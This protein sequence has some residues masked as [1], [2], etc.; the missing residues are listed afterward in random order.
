MGQRQ[1]HLEGGL[2]H[3]PNT[4][5]LVAEMEPLRQLLPGIPF[6]AFPNDSALHFLYV[7]AQKLPYQKGFPQAP[8]K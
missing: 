5:T 3:W 4:L 8:Y 2:Q 6:P 7:S 1:A